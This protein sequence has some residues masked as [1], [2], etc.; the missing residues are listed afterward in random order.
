MA[1][2]APDALKA[3]LGTR[4]RRLKKVSD[5]LPIVGKALEKAESLLEDIDPTVQL[6]AANTI[7]QGAM[8][9]GK[10]LEVG[11]LEARL[12]ELEARLATQKE[13]KK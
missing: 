4:R 6:K 12:I 10:L 7:F 2:P 9:F 1:N 11:E 13:V 8:A 3:R 5:V